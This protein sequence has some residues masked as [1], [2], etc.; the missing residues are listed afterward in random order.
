MKKKAIVIPSAGSII[1]EDGKYHS[2]TYNDGDAFGTLGG[3]ARVEA[4]AILAKKYPEY[5]VVATCKGGG[6][7]IIPT[8]AEVMKQELLNLGVDEKQIILEEKSTATRNGII[9]A[10]A[11]AREHNWDSIIFVSNEYHIP[12]LRLMA[13]SIDPSIKTEYISAEE[14]I[15]NERPEFYEIF[16]KV[17]SSIPYKKRLESEARGIEAMRSGKYQEAKIEDKKERVV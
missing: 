16:E 1:G 5:L 17:K 8:H 4:G 7:G 11:L 10:F 14:V 3:Y 2:T 15:I 13:E 6:N 9:E 12:R